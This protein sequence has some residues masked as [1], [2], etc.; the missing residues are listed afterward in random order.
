METETTER[1]KKKTTKYKNKPK[2]L[3]FNSDF[4][5]ERI[6]N[7]FVRQTLSHFR[8]NAR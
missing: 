4:S 3:V 8:M 1:N 6:L 5:F 7:E 2:N